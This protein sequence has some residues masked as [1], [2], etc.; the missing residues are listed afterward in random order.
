MRTIKSKSPGIILLVI[1]VYFVLLYIV[2][3]YWTYSVGFN[4]RLLTTLSFISATIWW[5][6]LFWA[7]H[8]TTFQF[9]SLYNS[10]KLN[11]TEAEEEIIKKEQVSIAIV[12]PTCNDL[13]EEALKSCFNQ[14]YTNFHVYICDDSYIDSIKER[15][16]TLSYENSTICTVIRRNDN[17][18]YK[19]GNLNNAI[20]K[21][22]KEDWICLADSDQFFGND[23]LTKIC[24]EIP[25]N[26]SMISYIQARN[27]ARLITD[28]SEFQNVMKDEITLYYTRD[29]YSRDKYGFVPL[30]GHGALIN[31]KIFLELGG[32][33][34]L[35]SEDFSFALNSLSKGYRNLYAQNVQSYELYPF[36]F[37]AFV[38]RMKKFSG[39]A[40]ELIRKMVPR[41]LF[42]QKVSKIEKWDFSIMLLWYILMPFILVNGF[43]SAY[44][45]HSFWINEIPFIHPILPYIYSY[46]LISILLIINS[47]QEKSFSSSLKFYFWTSAVYSSTMPIA[48]YNFIKGFFIKPKFIITPKEKKINKINKVNI[49]VNVIF[50]CFGII[51]S[52]K[53]WSPFSW[54]LLGY[55]L[56][57]CFFPFYMHINNK[58]LIGYLTRS[59]LIYIPGLFMFWALISLWKQIL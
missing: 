49:T 2:L 53:Y 54:F 28:M 58:N 55:S 39:A 36:D 18:G 34:E 46:M 20:T 1:I 12:Y 22:I 15:I 4:N 44:V 11:I 23:F 5:C 10:S 13:D 6:I 27:V 21:N 42:S 45:T 26:S 31:R 38:I 16:N 35:V 3:N 56:S 37:G 41:F 33:P 14:T 43:I 8:H 48:S 32:F 24:N 59:I 19:A 25:F 51:F 17:K 40:S 57:Y 50:G 47:C 30:L 7:M 52:L 29:L 9:V